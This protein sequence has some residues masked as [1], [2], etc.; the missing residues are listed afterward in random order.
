MVSNV[1]EPVAPPCAGWVASNFELVSPRDSSGCF[2]PAGV[3]A[4]PSA[5]EHCISSMT[6]RPAWASL[7]LHAANSKTAK[8][9]MYEYLF[10]IGRLR[11]LAA[12]L[13]S[14]I[15]CV[16]KKVDPPRP[17]AARLK[18]RWRDRRPVRRHDTTVPRGR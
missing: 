10:I 16:N 1:V 9:A 6:I 4:I 18:S 13:C 5:G 8:P 7:A 15:P 11:E 2:S 12:S 17:L 3:A 14:A